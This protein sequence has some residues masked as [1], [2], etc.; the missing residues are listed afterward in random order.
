MTKFDHLFLALFFSGLCFS[1]GDNYPAPIYDAI[2][3]HNTATD[4]WH[5][6]ETG[7]KVFEAIEGKKNSRW[8]LWIFRNHESVVYK[9]DPNRSARVIKEHFG[10]EHSGGILNVDRYSA[11]KAI[12]KAGLFVLAFCWAHVRRD[13]LEYAKAYP[14]HE[15]WGMGGLG[16]WPIFM[17]ALYWVDERQMI[18]KNISPGT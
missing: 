4:H 10:S 9:I 3:A 7:W 1:R 6:D 14:Q 15:A 16:Y 13:F 8:Y 18:F 11:Y 5:A 17:N 2:A 12:A